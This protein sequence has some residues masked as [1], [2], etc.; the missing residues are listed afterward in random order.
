MKKCR[1]LFPVG[2][3]SDEFNRPIFRRLYDNTLFDTIILPLKA[4]NFVESYKITQTYIDVYKP[5]IIFITGDRIEA[6]SA[7]CCA[8][9]NNILIAHYGSGITNYPL[10]TLDDV[11]R[12]CITLMTDIAL[13]ED[14]KSAKNVNDLW[15]TIKKYNGNNIHITGITH[16]DDIVINESLVPPRDYDL[17][18]YNPPTRNQEIMEQEIDEIH[19]YISPDREFIWIEPN[20]DLQWD[21]Y[22]ENFYKFVMLSTKPRPQYLGLLKNCTRFISNS[23]DIYYIAPKWLKPEQIILIG[24]RNK[25]RSTPAKLKTGASQRIVKI[26]ENWWISKNDH[27]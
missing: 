18:V 7:A 26:L 20:P 16:L 22:P 24:E 3:R 17:I 12:H 1:I 6:M 19:N 14:E 23:S 10:S 2:C 13:C 15:V 5:D 9:Q 8:F 11:N 21:Y 4:A 25:N 27:N